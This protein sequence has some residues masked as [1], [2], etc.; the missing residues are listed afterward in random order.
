MCLVYSI[1]FLSATSHCNSRVTTDTPDLPIANGRDSPQGSTHLEDVERATF[2]GL[3]QFETEKGTLT[4]LPLLKNQFHAMMLKKTLYTRRNWILLLVQI[5]IPVILTI[6][7]VLITKSFVISETLPALEITLDKYIN[8]V[9][10]LSN[11][12]SADSPGGRFS[13]EYSKMIQDHNHP[14]T[15][16]NLPDVRDYIINLTGPEL[17]SFNDRYLIGVTVEDNNIT[18][19]FNNQ[20]YHTIP[21]SLD[22]SFN[23]MLKAHCPDCSISVVN[24]PLPFTFDTRLQ[25]LRAG[26]NM[27]FQLASN[28]GFSMCFVA[29]FYV[30]FYI[31][32][33]VTKAKLLQFVS[34]INIW[35][36]WSTAFLWDVITFLL[37]AVIVMFTVLV[38]QEEGWKSASDM[39]RL[40]VLLSSFVWCV[41]PFVYL[42][43]MIFDVPSSGFIKTVMVGI[44]L[45]IACFYVVFS[46]ESPILELEHVAEKMTWV[47][48]V[49]PHFA[50]TQ[51]LSNLN[52]INS[53]IPVRERN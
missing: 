25:M 1:P 32:E 48:L 33:R 22:V 9:V 12:A 35:T 36:F 7:T 6:V 50:L 42:F 3:N 41:L 34:G 5:L 18:T 21:L 30:I 27:G 20:P 29:A 19:W 16:V 13:A 40:F 39:W 26:N 52:I 51:G 45:G 14:T 53:I 23:A 17:V 44:F 11:H 8:P 37:T 24:E 43:S 10:I 49:V 2:V 47:F 46:L 15:L 4:G 31:R 38:F 28:V